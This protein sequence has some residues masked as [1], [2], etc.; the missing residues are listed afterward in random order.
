MSYLYLN[1]EK[2][3]HS[4]LLPSRKRFKVCVWNDIYNKRLKKI[5]RVYFVYLSDFFL[6][7]FQC[8]T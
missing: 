8:I 4:Y 6:N 2:Y 1:A 7:Y 5:R 3:L